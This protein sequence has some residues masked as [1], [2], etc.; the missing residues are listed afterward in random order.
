ML[1]AL[2]KMQ[3]SATG[4]FLMIF[5]VGILIFGDRKTNECAYTFAWAYLRSSA[6]SGCA[7]GDWAIS[8]ADQFIVFPDAKCR[9]SCT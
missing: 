1:L 7:T 5:L 4:H 9:H 3:L 2:D 8:V 6:Y